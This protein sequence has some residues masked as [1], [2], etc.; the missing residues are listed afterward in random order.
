[1]I[2]VLKA[3][4]STA[5]TPWSTSWMQVYCPHRSRS[6]LFT[7][8]F[9]RVVLCGKLIFWQPRPPCWIF[10][11][12]GDMSISTACLLTAQSTLLDLH[13]LWWHIQN[14]LLY[15]PVSATKLVWVVKTLLWNIQSVFLG[16]RLEHEWPYLRIHKSILYGQP[17][18]RVA[19]IHSFMN[20]AVDYGWPCV[21]PRTRGILV[22]NH[23]YAIYTY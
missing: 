13:H 4:L 14:V 20:T 12:C 22:N 5:F 16:S 19:F 17:Y 6:H 10:T 8:L 11:I 15:A 21:G 7:N 1:M 3:C 18:I 2:L 9:F 23:A